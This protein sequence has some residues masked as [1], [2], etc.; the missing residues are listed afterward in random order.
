MV[1]L[2]QKLPSGKQKVGH[3]LYIL[4]DNGDS[5][6]TKTITV[7]GA[8]VCVS[9][10]Y[11]DAL[12]LFEQNATEPE[13]KRSRHDVGNIT[14]QSPTTTNPFTDDFEKAIFQYIAE[15][16]GIAKN[17]AGAM[18]CSYAEGYLN[19]LRAFGQ[20]A[21]QAPC[22]TRGMLLMFP[23]STSIYKRGNP[24]SGFTLSAP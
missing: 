19:V 20:K 17:N 13:T 8:S 1:T 10:A 9:A 4:A 2:H 21:V 18:P 12:T 11:V 23:Y 3:N 6:E 16:V 22:Y 15:L 14:N 24:A 5:S 7:H